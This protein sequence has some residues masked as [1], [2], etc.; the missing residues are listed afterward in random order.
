[1]GSALQIPFWL[2]LGSS[3][4]K[5]VIIPLNFSGVD[6]LDFEVDVAGTSNHV[7][8]AQY[9]VSDPEGSE[10]FTRDF[11][12]L[13]FPTPDR[14]DGNLTFG[15]FGSGTLVYT[16]LSAATAGNNN[17]FE[18]DDIT[19]FTFDDGIA[20]LGDIKAGLPVTDLGTEIHVVKAPNVV[21]ILTHDDITTVYPID[22]GVSLVKSFDGPVWSEEGQ[23]L[24]GRVNLA[25]TLT[26]KTKLILKVG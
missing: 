12:I 5:E 24:Y 7:L 13:L 14:K 10:G 8:G 1:M 19:R 3:F 23:K 21:P 9:Y 6:T 22:Q 20:F 16:Q 17:E 26:A 18:V 11:E 15:T 4:A 25:S 2:P